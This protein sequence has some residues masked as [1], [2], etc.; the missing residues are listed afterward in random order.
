MQIIHLQV[1]N[2]YKN[3]IAIFLNN[4]KSF[5]RTHIY[6]RNYNGYLKIISILEHKITIFK[7]S[8]LTRHLR[9]TTSVLK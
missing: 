4:F 2:T 6:E 7:F 5:Y 9:Y 3:I 1:S 8:F